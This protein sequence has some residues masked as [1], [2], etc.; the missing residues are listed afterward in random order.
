MWAE[1]HQLRS[2]EY[3]IVK[4]IG[5]GGFGLTY[6]ANKLTV[7]PLAPKLDDLNRD[8]AKREHR[9]AGRYA[10]DLREVDLNLNRARFEDVVSDRLQQ[11]VIKSPNRGFR[12]DR[13]YEKFVR[14][15]QHE[16]QVLGKISHPNVVRVLDFFE[17]EG[18]PCLVME[19]V[20][21]ETLSKS[22]GQRG[23]LT[24]EE[25]VQYFG[26]LAVALDRVHQAE[27]IHCDVHPGN[28][29]LRQV[30][31]QTQEPVLIDF[32]SAKSLQPSTLTVTTTVNQ[33]YAP[34]EQQQDGKRHPTLDV[35]GLA[36]TL[37]F[38]VTGEKPEPAMN[39]KLYGDRLQPPQK[40]RSSLSNCLNQAILKGMALEA[41]DRPHSMQ[42]WIKLL[43]SQQEPAF[44]W[45]PLF[46]FLLGFLPI[47]ILLGLSDHWTMAVA[48]VMVWAVAAALIGVVVVGVVLIAPGTLELRGC[49]AMSMIFI[50]SLA[51]IG[52]ISGHFL[53]IGFWWSL[54][55]IAIVLFQ[56][57][58]TIGGIIIANNILAKLYRP[59]L[60]FTIYVTLSIGGLVLGGVVGWWLKLSGF[61]LP[62]I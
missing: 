17:E 50:L 45:T 42:V 21:G 4:Q 29:I 19:Y 61:K 22:V 30:D 56:L 37:Y 24:E 54:K 3:E 5:F 58:A 8:K 26:K 34:Y 40:L 47:G 39:R 7:D 28:I 11:V 44:P 10:G 55:Y 2:G 46:F 49:L 18:I 52:M 1:G 31:A 53:G 9:I 59:A 14:R 38:A 13:D 62:T 43:L 6:L 41:D 35:Y 48:W 23:C 32:G 27:L 51:I 20:K 15:F 16:A 12:D 60:I 36:A 25:A 33:N 57:I